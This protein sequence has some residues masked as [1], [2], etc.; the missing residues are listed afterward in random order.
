MHEIKCEG[1]KCEE[2]LRVDNMSEARLTYVY[3]TTQCM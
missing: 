1:T 3:A 2:V